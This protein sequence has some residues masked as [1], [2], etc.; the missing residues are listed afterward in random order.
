MPELVSR[1]LLP[2]Y[3][4]EVRD[5]DDGMKYIRSITTIKISYF[6]AFGIVRFIRRSK[7]YFFFIII[8][9]SDSFCLNII[10]NIISFCFL[11]L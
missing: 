2:I 8:C 4:F 5:F 9:I 3:G 11:S 10:F 6:F 7:T 1:N